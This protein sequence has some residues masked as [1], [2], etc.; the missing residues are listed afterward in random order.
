[1]LM[2]MD[3]L[4]V[5]TPMGF[6]ALLRQLSGAVLDQLYPPACVYCDAPT[7]TPDGVCAKCWGQLRAISAPFCP[8]LGLPFELPLGPDARSA[9]AIADPP[10][11]DRA[12]SAYVYNQIAGAIVSRLKYGDRPEL[13]KFC[14]RT[15]ATNCAELLEGDPLLVPVPLHRGRQWQRRYNQSTE[16]CRELATL[17]G[18]EMAPLLV[19]RTRRTRPQVGL[20]GQQRTRNVAGAFGVHAEALGITKGR[21]VVLVDDVITTGST[22]NALTHALKRAGIVHIDVMSF[23]RVVIGVEIP[24]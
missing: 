13:A 21:R 7:A 12:R 1:M 2:E 11:F 3:E 5:K 23:A 20:S 4:P 24:I 9:A 8:V 6:R 10:P 19:R 16:I 18:L 22:M 14:A 15:M 17:T